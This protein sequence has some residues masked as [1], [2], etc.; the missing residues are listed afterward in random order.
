MID[1]NTNNL[2]DFAVRDYCH[3]YFV[4]DPLQVI[5][6][7]LVRFKLS[8]QNKMEKTRP[9]GFRPRMEEEEVLMD[10]IYLSPVAKKVAHGS[11]AGSPQGPATPYLTV[12]QAFQRAVDDLRQ[13][14][15]DPLV[16]GKEE[17]I[18]K[19]LDQL[20]EKVRSVNLNYAEVSD[21]ITEACD[22]ALRNLQEMTRKK[23]ETLLSLEIELRREQEQLTW[24]D[25]LVQSK[26]QNVLMKTD[27]Y[28]ASV[29]DYEAKLEFLKFWKNHAQFRNALSRSR[30]TEVQTLKS[31]QGDIR[32]NPD[33]RFIQDA[34]YSTSVQ[35]TS[36]DVSVD[37]TPSVADRVSNMKRTTAWNP[38][39]ARTTIQIDSEHKAD[40]V[41]LPMSI[42]HL[43]DDEMVAIQ[44]AIMSAIESSSVDSS[45][46]LPASIS[47]PALSGERYHVPLHSLLKGLRYSDSEHHITAH[48]YN[49]SF[50]DDTDE[51]GNTMQLNE[52]SKNIFGV[53][54]TSILGT[55]DSTV[56]GK[57]FQRLKLLCSHHLVSPFRRNA[58]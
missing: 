9:N 11:S 34:F 36:D 1:V 41:G 29:D 52:E 18:G 42:Q 58:K 2:F 13:H 49:S 12:D 30:P 37:S 24:I 47:R 6:K 51:D 48:V 14:E 20:D 44:G 33:I 40:S 46:P 45:L 32:V 50:F 23:L 56:P 16:S 21:A 55:K 38:S 8:K 53:S 3:R 10:P 17:W 28:V 35:P 25:S 7:Y 43:V 4:K 19:Q 27:N 39:F 26:L 31:I 15:K 54:M 22:N 5:P 57:Y